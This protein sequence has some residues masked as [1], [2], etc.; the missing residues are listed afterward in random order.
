VELAG[1]LPCQQ[2]QHK[3][4]TNLHQPLSVIFST[5]SSMIQ[6]RNEKKNEE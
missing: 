3:H 6:Q 4:G 5:T 2:Q 1:P